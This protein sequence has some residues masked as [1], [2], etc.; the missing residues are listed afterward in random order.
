V[1]RPLSVILIA[2]WLFLGAALELHS[3]V[4]GPIR[5][6]FFNVFA[7]HLVRFAAVAAYIIDIQVRAFIGIGLLDRRPAARIAGMVFF[8]Y[9]A[10]NAVVTFF[11]PG[12]LLAFVAATEAG[13]HFTHFDA[14]TMVFL[15]DAHVLSVVVTV[16]VALL[17]LYFLKTRRAAFYPPPTPP[18][19]S[20]GDVSF[21]MEQSSTAHSSDPPAGQSGGAP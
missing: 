21:G 13:S 9:A 7:F 10:L 20:S 11:R 1:K 14:E 18:A 8:A 5:W 16:G 2:I 19:A 3:L 15:R 4:E 17:A 6:H 12:S